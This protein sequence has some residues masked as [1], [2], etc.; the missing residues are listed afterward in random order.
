MS[1]NA[2]NGGGWWQICGDVQVLMIN[3]FMQ[4]SVYISESAEI[5]IRSFLRSL[6]LFH[7]RMATS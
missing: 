2:V 3:V 1:G 4:C 7:F 5:Q 6:V